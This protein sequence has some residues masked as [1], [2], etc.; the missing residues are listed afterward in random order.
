MFEYCS[1]YKPSFANSLFLI[2]TD[3]ISST[4]LFSK[5][6]KFD[7]YSF[8]NEFSRC[9]SSKTSPSTRTAATAFCTLKYF[10][11]ISFFSFLALVTVDTNSY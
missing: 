9:S 10:L 6:S 4:F 3:L 7:L 2:V 11:S 1:S 8:F 5:R